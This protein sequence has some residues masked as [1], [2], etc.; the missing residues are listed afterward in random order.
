MNR[1]LLTFILALVLASAAFGKGASEATIEGPGLDGAV[2]IPGDGEGGGTTLGRLVELTG[3]FASVFEQSPNPMLETQPDVE[4]GPRYAVHYVM[5]GPEGQESI[6]EQHL[7]PYAQPYPVSYTKPGQ[8][9]WGADSQDA[10]TRH[11][12]QHTFGGWYVSTAELKQT[13]AEIGLPSR[14]PSPGDSDGIGGWQIALVAVG[15]A[16]ALGIIV[17]IDRR[18]RAPAPA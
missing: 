12:G 1:F 15:A 7:Y 5:P 2:A 14:P 11:D 8:P 4:L 9:F 13:L 18:R 6:L 3:F 16:I 17:G 10:A